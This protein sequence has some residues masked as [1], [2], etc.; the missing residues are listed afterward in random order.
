[1]GFISSSEVLVTRSTSKAVRETLVAKQWLRIIP[2][3]F[4]VAVLVWVIVVGVEETQI[5]CGLLVLAGGMH[6]FTKDMMDHVEQRDRLRDK[7]KPWERQPIAYMPRVVGEWMD[8]GRNYWV[9]HHELVSSEYRANPEFI[10]FA[11][12]ERRKHLE[13][14]CDITICYY[15]YFHDKQAPYV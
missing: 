7:S 1:M 12:A 3:L 9:R 14:K 10:Q 8:N 6:L 11:E 5:V 13:G 2:F 4:A 15:C